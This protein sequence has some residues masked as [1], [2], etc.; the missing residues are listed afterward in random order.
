MPQ[1]YYPNVP[2]FDRESFKREVRNRL[3]SNSYGEYSGLFTDRQL[4]TIVEILGES[5]TRILN[6]MFSQVIQ[7]PTA[8]DVHELFLKKLV[9]GAPH[10]QE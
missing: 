7:I 1:M 2:F 10:E 4:D 5:I 9:E 6:Q 3:G 8:E